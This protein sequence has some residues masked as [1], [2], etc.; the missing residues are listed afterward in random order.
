MEAYG[1]GSYKAFFKYIAHNTHI[2]RG[3]S[4]FAH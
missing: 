4:H 1:D 2:P 3:L